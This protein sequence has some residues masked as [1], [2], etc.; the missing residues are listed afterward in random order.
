MYMEQRVSLGA[1][2]NRLNIGGGSFK[3][4]AVYS[5]RSATTHGTQ[6]DRLFMFRFLKSSSSL[7]S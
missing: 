7:F 2:D 5:K 6:L 1:Y 4:M 3:I